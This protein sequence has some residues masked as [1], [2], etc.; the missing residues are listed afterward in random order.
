MK[1][2]KEKTVRGGL[3]RLCAQAVDFILRLVSLMVLARL[4][5][6]KDFGLVGMVTA[7]TGVLILFRDFGLSAAVIQRPNVTDAQLSTL[8]WINVAVGA[9]LS[10]LTAAM[11]PFIAAFYH[12]P[13]LVGVASALACSFLF[14]AAGIQHG[15]LLQRQMR[16]TALAVVSI[17]SL[18]VS[19]ATAIGGAM[20]G[21]G[22][23]ALV[24]MTV[25]N[26]LFNTVGFFL[27]THWIPGRPQRRIGIRSMLHFGGTVTLNGLIV[28]TASNFEK[29]LLGRFW[30]ADALG[31]YGRAYQRSNIPTANLNGA[32]G[33]VAFSALSRLQ[34]DPVRLK[35]YFLKGYS[36]VLAMTVP[37]TVACTLF[38]DDMIL[39]FL[40][41][42]W[43]AA[44]I[45]FRLLAPTILVFAIANPLGWLVTSLGMVR[46][47]L[48]MGLVIA[49]IM[50]VS[51]MIGLPYGPKGVA[52]AY[53]AVMIS[54]TIPVIA[55]SVHGTAI[56]VRDVLLMASRP[57]VSS[58]VAAALAFTVRLLYAQSLSP[59]PRLAL[60]N[61][62]LFTT[63]AA[64][65]LFATGQKA[66]YMDL[67]RSLTSRTAAEESSLASA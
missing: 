61:G 29:I 44:G 59:L 45:I 36:L 48:K 2:L 50:I 6:P 25:A 10:L 58:I 33:E 12:E 39:V 1:D 43:K 7:F 14:N 26:P 64:I 16:F 11:A 52:F 34:H 30:G 28:Y 13:R 55:W 31:L 4:L 3:A 21:Y 54:W 47:S 56:S 20:A 62:V 23:W 40:G 35:S 57:L 51:Y 18:V 63:F 17:I 9:F 53:S 32:V 65:L 38:A 66:F 5:G 24:G 37:S 8:F 46:R 19:S 15:A 42:K 60:E 67:L 49:P 22:Y 27:A 41:P